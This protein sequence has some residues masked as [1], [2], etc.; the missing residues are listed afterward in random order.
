M[1]N[2]TFHD[3]EELVWIQS[4][5]TPIG[6]LLA[7][8]N[9]KGICLLEFDQTN[10]TRRTVQKITKVLQ[11]EIHNA[12]HPLHGRLQDQLEAYFN[13]QRT[14]FDL[15]L[16]M[17][18]TDFQKKVWTML[19]DIP[20]GQTRTYAGMAREYGNIKTIRAMAQANA[21]N[22]LAILVPCHRVIGAG[23]SL[24]GYGGGIERKRFLLNL[25]Q[26]DAGTLFSHNQM[27]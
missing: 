1:T 26:N 7:G 3:S 16:V 9:E 24:T 6:P 18:G 23:G 20:Y 25:E 22:H 2:R 10:R 13:R 8:V 15:P 12:S 19:R 5:K 27:A 4:I 17:V 14:T 11:A 21:K